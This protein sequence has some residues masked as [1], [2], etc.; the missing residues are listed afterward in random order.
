VLKYY[1]PVKSYYKLIKTLEDDPRFDKKKAQKKL[2]K[3]VEN[4]EFP[5]SVKAEMIVEHFYG[6]VISKGKV[7]GKARAM[8][9]TG[10][11]DRA[12]QYYHAICRCLETRKSP[13]KAIVA[14]SGDKEYGDEMVN[15]SSINGFPS[16][17]IEKTLKTD[18]YRFLIVAEKFQTGYDEPLL[19]T[20][21]VDKILTDIKAVQTLSRLN[22]AHPQKL[23]TFILDFANEKEIILEAFSRY[24]RTTILSGETDPNKMYDLIAT[25]EAYQV[26]TQY[27]IN[28]FVE[29]YLG[30]AERD[31]LDPI[32][33]VCANLYK[34]LDEE[35]QVKFKSSAK[36]FVRTYGF[37]GAI[38][39][40]GNAEWEKLSIFM[41]LLLPKLPSPTEEDLSQGILDVIDL[42]SYRLE[43][44]T[45]M[46][47]LLKDSDSEIEPVP[48]GGIG[49]K[50]EAELDWLSSILNQFNDFFG[51]IQWKDVDNVKRQI[52][53]IPAKV[54]ENEKY[55][56]A[57]KNADKQESRTECDHAL[58]NVVY[59]IMADSLELYKEYS[60][61]LDF[62]KW[63][64]DKIFSLTYNTEGKPFNAQKNIIEDRKVRETDKAV[65]L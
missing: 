27:H 41:N 16:S 22:R 3:Y 19:H 13:Y 47:I 20:M 46:S 54:S 1:T 64:S 32:L 50:S 56:N 53:E 34:A 26:Y 18:P 49:N 14:F 33:D 51:N 59:N 60:D 36:G 63:L 39:P 7:G 5:L 35:A 29:L 11:I 2:R 25:M 61:N 24:Y 6:Q 17:A 55:Q 43:K 12:I 31:K 4:D 48:T 44:R 28:S 10:S 23:D 57:M 52:A 40:Y 42:D 30:G 15:E 62:K 8:V 58:K 45:Q 21:Y 38:L 37:L 9:V 65:M